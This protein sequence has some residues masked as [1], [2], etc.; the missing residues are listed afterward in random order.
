VLADHLFHAPEQ[1][2]MFYLLVREA[3]ERFECELVTE[4]LGPAALQHL[5][6][7]E[8]FDETEDVSVCAALDLAQQASLVH[9]KGAQAIDK[10]QPVGQKLAREVERA[11][12]Q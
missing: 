3:H 9:R 8:A 12:S 7:D 5:C 11:A 4:H 10:G 2:L 1:L 6:A